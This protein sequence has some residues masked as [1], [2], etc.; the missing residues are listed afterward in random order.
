MGGRWRF[1]YMVMVFV[2]FYIMGCVL[3][4]SVVEE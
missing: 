3:V 1:G 2:G 4:V